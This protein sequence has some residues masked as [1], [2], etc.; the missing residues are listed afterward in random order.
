MCDDSAVVTKG[1]T[2]APEVEIEVTPR[3]I[4]DGVMAYL[5]TDLRSESI[6][7]AFCNALVALAASSTRAIRLSFPQSSACV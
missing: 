6:E 2:G 3:M 1:G 7:I 5:D 4:F